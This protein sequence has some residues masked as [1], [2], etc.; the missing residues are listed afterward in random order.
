MHHWL[1]LHAHV[2]QKHSTANA[3]V[4]H[5]QRSTMQQA[6]AAWHGPFLQAARRRRDQ[7]ARAETHR[8]LKLAAAAFGVWRVPYLA[9]ARARRQAWQRAEA[10]W[11]ANA[12]HAAAAAWLGFVAAQHAKRAR[13]QALREQ[14]AP[15]RQQRVFLAWRLACQCRAAKGHLVGA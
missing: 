11:R 7:L 13:L 5:Y 12:L 15:G 10:L 2:R 4:Q 3:M 14:L 1:A 8:Q 9:A 6:F